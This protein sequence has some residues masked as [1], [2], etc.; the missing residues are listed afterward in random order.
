VGATT[1]GQGAIEP[2]RRAALIRLPLPADQRGPWRVRVRVTDGQGTVETRID[3]EDAPTLRPGPPL[4][5]RGAGSPRA[6]M[7]PVAEL[8]FRRTE[9][10]RIQWPI[11]RDT[12]LPAA[13]ILDRR[14]QPLGSPLPV[15]ESNGDGE[16]VVT[17]DLML[18]SLAA[19]DY[20]IQLTAGQGDAA[21]Q[22]LVPFRV[23]R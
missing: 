18:G 10:L 14:G 20:V 12:S 9:R 8:S 11:A 21:E 23:V 16:R 5:L 19:G 6:A 1:T 17:F 22:Q 4:V 15:S 3:A 13:Q 7:Q 2:G